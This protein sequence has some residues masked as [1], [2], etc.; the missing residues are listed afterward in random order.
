[1]VTPTRQT[2]RNLPSW[3]LTKN[4]IMSS[5]VYTVEGTSATAVG[6]EPIVRVELVDTVN[7]A[8]VCHALPEK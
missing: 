5:K 2:S 7:N 4:G 6:R 1:M 3:I 8:L